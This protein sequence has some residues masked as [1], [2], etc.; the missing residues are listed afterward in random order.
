M[1]AGRPK[2][3]EGKLTNF[4]SKITQTHKDTIAAIVKTGPYNSVRELLEAWTDN[5]L[6]SNPETAAKVKNFLELTKGN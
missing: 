2:S 4:N 5:Y 1:T 3:V 6:E